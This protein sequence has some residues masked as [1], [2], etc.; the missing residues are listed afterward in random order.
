MSEAF[1]E[2]FMGLTLWL[3]FTWNRAPHAYYDQKHMIRKSHN[4]TFYFLGALLQ[5]WDVPIVL[6]A[7]SLVSGT[8]KMSAP[9]APKRFLVVPN[10]SQRLLTNAD[11]RSSKEEDAIL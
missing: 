10:V 8:T 1:A 5:F 2:Q 3:T 11:G 4:L 9:S 7:G 6:A